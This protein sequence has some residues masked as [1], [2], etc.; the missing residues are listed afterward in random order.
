MKR[1]AVLTAVAAFTASPAFASDAIDTA[2]R[3]VQLSDGQLDG[4]TAGIFDFAINVAPVIQTITTTA[5]TLQV[6]AANAGPTTQ[7]ANNVA[8]AL[9]LIASIPIAVAGP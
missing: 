2:D 1:L 7:A 5:S 4:V 3:A 6:A 9:G 8:A